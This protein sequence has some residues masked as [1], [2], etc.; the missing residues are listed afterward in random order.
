MEYEMESH[1][2]NKQGMEN[3][4]LYM[5]F[6][7]GLGYFL[8]M[9]AIFQALMYVVGTKGIDNAISLSELTVEDVKTG[10]FVEGDI[11]YSGGIYASK[12]FTTNGVVT[13]TNNYYVIPFGKD[14]DRFMGFQTGISEEEI[15]RLDNESMQYFEGKTNEIPTAMR[16]SGMLIPIT[17]EMKTYYQMFMGELPEEMY[18]NYFLYEMD[19]AMLQ[20]ISGIICWL[21]GIGVVLS[22]V[23]NVM[24][25]K[26]AGDTAGKEKLKIIRNKAILF[27]LMAIVAVLAILFVYF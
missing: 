5:Y 16:V 19:K 24:Q 21:L 1:N 9:M 3:K 2:N 18:V 4:T 8:L 26:I 27:W 23:S 6:M 20:R 7:R 11:P 17:G 14:S 25:R 13:S 12:E 15:E 10:V 22:I